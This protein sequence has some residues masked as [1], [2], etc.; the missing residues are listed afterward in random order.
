M[1]DEAF[2]AHPNS[3]EL[4]MQDF[5][6][7]V[8]TGNWKAAQQVAQRL[9]KSFGSPSGPLSGGSGDR[10]L[11]WAVLGALLQADDTST[12]EAMRGVLHKLAG[13]L[14]EQSEVPPYA[15][16]E[17]MHVHLTVMQSLEENDKAAALLESEE[18]KAVVKM[19]LVVDEMRREI[20]RRR[21]D[22]VKEGERAR[23]RITEEKY[24]S[25]IFVF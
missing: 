19:S 25:D 17:R 11:Y 23:Q 13:R 16:A 1:Y 21:G 5:F 6:A 18:G 10:Y 8:R 22:W 4:G 12:S 24:V 14:L 2:R 7:N 15:T 20:V 9:H 3:E